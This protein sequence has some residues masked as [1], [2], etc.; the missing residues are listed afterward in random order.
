MER[1][2]KLAN[3]P[4]VSYLA[5]DLGRAGEWM[6]FR[7][8]SLSAFYSLL[9]LPVTYITWRHLLG[10]RAM[11]WTLALLA[12]SS[13][14]I[15]Y[16]QDAK[17]YSMLWLLATAS[18]GCFLNALSG[19]PGRAWWLAGYGFTTA[20]LPLTSYVGIVPVLIQGIYGLAL[21]VLKR[22]RALLVF[23]AGAIALAAM[24]PTTLHL[25][26]PLSAASNRTGISW[27]PGVTWTQVPWELCRFVGALL[28]GYR[29]SEE[30]ARRLLGVASGG[31]LR[32]LRHRGDGAAG[33]RRLAVPGT[34]AERAGQ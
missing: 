9:T 6:T 17:M 33:D 10:R 8:V 15:A 13:Y 16:S 31:R 34:A 30:A 2:R 32:S 12:L 19:R 7:S 27:I 1:P 5:L 22:G 14:Q 23:D 21:L 20:C 4:T 25:S 3:G 11:S 18:S 28:L 26:S 29:P 24:I